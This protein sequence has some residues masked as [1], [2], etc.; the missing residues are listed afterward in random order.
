MFFFISIEKSRW[1]VFFPKK[2]FLTHFLLAASRRKTAICLGVERWRV[3]QRRAERRVDRRAEAT[4]DDHQ[5]HRLPWPRLR[6]RAQRTIRNRFR[7]SKHFFF[8]GSISGNSILI[9]Q[10]CFLLPLFCYKLSIKLLFLEAI[11]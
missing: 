5:L 7:S 11:F 1:E 8:K 9:F 4:G 10:T 2:L 3:E 6:H